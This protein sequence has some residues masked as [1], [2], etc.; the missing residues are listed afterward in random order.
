MRRMWPEEFNALLDNAKEVDLEIPVAAR[1]SATPGH[2]THRKALRV[3][4]TQADFERV[5]PLAEARYRLAGKHAGKAITLVTTTRI[6]TTGTRPMAARRTLRPR[7]AIATPRNMWWC[8]FCS[9]MWR[10]PRRPEGSGLFGE[11]KA[12]GDGFHRPLFDS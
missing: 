6:I 2:A 1:D 12:G 11:S 9:T 4:L 7:A 10:K 5:W 3:R 8:I